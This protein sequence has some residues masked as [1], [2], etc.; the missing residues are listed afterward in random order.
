MREIVET[1]LLP[2]SAISSSPAYPHGLMD[3][4]SDVRMI[5]LTFCFLCSTT[6][7]SCFK[8]K[9]DGHY[10]FIFSP[11]LLQLMFPFVPHSYMKGRKK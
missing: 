4:D 7:C 9:T 1:T 5:N 8:I 6:I 11:V 2:A 10:F 3:F